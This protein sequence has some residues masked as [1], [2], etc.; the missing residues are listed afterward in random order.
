MIILLFV[1]ICDFHWRLRDSDLHISP[2]LYKLLVWVG[3][4]V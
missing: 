2:E 1:V 3:F 4:F